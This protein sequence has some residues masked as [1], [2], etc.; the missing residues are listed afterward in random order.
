MSQNPTV[1]LAVQRALTMGAVV[2]G[3]VAC[4]PAEAQEAPAPGT[5][6]ASEVQ[7]VVVTGTRVR[8]VDAETASPILVM[9]QALISQTGASTVGDL[10]NRIPSIAG[11]AMNP[12]LNN[13]GGF[14]ETNIELRGLDARRT[15][16]LLD[17]QR[18]NLVGNSG[19]V[20]VNQIPINAIDHVEVLA[21]GAGAIYGSDAIAGVVN[22]VT[23]KD[24][25]GLE[26]SGD[27]G[28]SSKHDTEHYNIGVMFGGKTDKF[29]FQIGGYYNNQKALG[30]GQRDWSKYA[31]YLYSGSLNKAGSSRTPTGRITI[32]T[33]LAGPWAPGGTCPKSAGG[34]VTRIDGTNGTTLNDYRC[35]VSPDDKFNFQPS[36]L[37]VTPQERGAL[38]TKVNYNIN[39]YVT[40]YGMAI[41]NHTHS[42]FQLAPLPFDANNDQI[43]ISKDN[44]YNP[45]GSDFGGGNAVG[46]V[47][48]NFLL[49]LLGI[50][51][52]RSD[53]TSDSV[54]SRVGLKGKIGDSG[55]NYDGSV[56]YNRLD[57]TANISG[58]F[59]SNQLQQAVGPSFVGP[60]GP[61]CGTP[62]APIG[63]CT[64]VNIFD[65]TDLPASATS[66]FTATYSTVNTFIS[67]AANLDF[68]GPLF[69]M[70]GRDALLAVGF[71]Y[72]E[73]SGA[74]TTS[75]VTQLIAPN[76]LSC[77]ISQE[78]CSA[79]SFGKYDVREGYAELFLPLLADLPLV[80][81]LNLDA[82]IR[83][84]DYS[85]FGSTTRA[86][87]KL[88]YR[89]IRDLLIRG[90]F[91]Q[92]FRVP[93][94]ADISSPPTI[95]SPTLNDLCNGYTGVNTAAYP[96]LTA[97]CA[98]VPTDGTFKEQQNQVTGKFTSTPLN[99]IVPLKPE[100]GKNY[101]FGAVYDSSLLQGLSL[102]ADYWNYTV[103]NLLQSQLDPNFSIQQCAT[104]GDPN[105]CKNSHR[106]TSGPNQGQVI[107]FDQPT[108]N[109]GGIKTDGMDFTL[110]YGFKGTPVG[111]FNFQVDWTKLMSWT[112]TASEGAAPIQIAGTFNKQF[113]MYAKDRATVN[114]G[115]A[116]WG[117]NALLTVR[118]ISD[119]EIP[120]TN[121]CDAN[122]NFIGWHLPSV[123]YIDLTAGYTIKQTGTQLRVGVLNIAD[124]TPPIAGINSFNDSAVTDVLTYDTIGRRYFIGFTQTF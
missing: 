32:P 120:L 91:A 43:V 69:K 72:I 124:K 57:Q 116:G 118:Y 5:A 47:N 96:H 113:G 85:A 40:A 7:E 86:S 11:A 75:T 94:I 20:D 50:G 82:G 95:N 54:I 102:S 19:A 15:L 87:F 41:Y 42:G 63:D 78:A 16:I 64:P 55:W 68:N 44:I 4:I 62:A 92:L 70:G 26:I 3:G 56:Q 71:D 38:F 36:N 73:L 123:T 48:P 61:T 81:S 79:N 106:Y 14:G 97:A 65:L 108:I 30:M 74:F 83:Y 13:G 60:L 49:R 51:D 121:C 2:A 28:E 21:Q 100:T 67:R 31:L 1:S 114:L 99:A 58:Y 45:F 76:Y 117:A 29:A 104:T 119:V 25:S 101:S 88:E 105:F 35:F 93:T 52:R 37:N 107:W 111:D 8:R 34:T 10:V 53:S 59:L 77:L 103:D 66:G 109:I 22:F 6:A 17:G 18:V 39:D 46:G 115:W 110:R 122:G 90:S 33:G 24:A 112:Y 27:W 23:R 9:D 89:P 84:S 12:A 80:H 98:G